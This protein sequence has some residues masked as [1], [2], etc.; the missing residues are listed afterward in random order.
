MP[1]SKAVTSICVGRE[2][3]IQSKEGI[4]KGRN[5]AAVLDHKV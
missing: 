3:K 2:G 5:P 4:M 1:W